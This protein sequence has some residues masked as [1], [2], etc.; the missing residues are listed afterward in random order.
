MVDICRM[1]TIFHIL[2]ANTPTAPPVHLLPSECAV[3]ASGKVDPHSDGP[4]G[5]PGRG[6]IA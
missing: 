4:F 3:T 2:V 1:C 6:L 5:G